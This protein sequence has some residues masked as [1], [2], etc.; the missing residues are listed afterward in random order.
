MTETS[1]LLFS[2]IKNN[3]ITKEVDI[4]PLV[5]F[6]LIFSLL[7]LSSLVRFWAKGW[8]YDLYILPTF[9]FK[10]FGFEWIEAPGDL[11]IY[12]LFS[13]VMLSTVFMFFGF[14]YRIA[15]A[16]FFLGFTYIE[17][18]DKT[19][20]LNHYYFVS[21][22][23]FLMVF[24]PANQYF[25][26]DCKLNPKL[27]SRTIQAWSINLLKLQLGIVYFFAGIAKLNYEWLVNAMPLKM[28]LPAHASKPVI[29]FLFKYTGVSYLFSWFGALY[30]L[31]IPFLLLSKKF[32]TMAYLLVIIFHVLTYWL[33]PI[34]MFPFIMISCTLIFFSE[35]FHKN[36]LRRLEVM[37]QWRNKDSSAF[38]TSRIGSFGILSIVL[39]VCF[40][41][42]FPFRHLVYEGPLFWHEQGYRFGWRV[43]LMEKAGT[44][45]FYASEPKTNK[46]FEIRNSDYLTA[47]QEKVM[48]TQPDMI[49]EFAHH[50][51]D[52][53]KTKGWKNPEIRSDV[54]VTLN[55][56]GTR[57]F[58]DSK[59][60]LVSIQDSWKEKQWILPF[61]N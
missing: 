35:E 8:I 3:L 31:A 28:W 51:A 57:P 4:A 16:V 13:L 26:I 60:N 37:V 18:I 45:F 36:L 52:D 43:M 53:L 17:L 14:F 21:L 56:S 25:S 11:G 9:H 59:T 12:V 1:K 10:Y 19:T 41:V 30:D 47:N 58:I 40:Q 38:S 61:E 5:I 34:G 20:Y 39:L 49:L 48:A 23:A 7:M 2:R 54:Y 42:V 27:Q 15:A 46:H 24:L 33:F 44:A 55:G 29:G 22:I 6:R 32:R 50:I